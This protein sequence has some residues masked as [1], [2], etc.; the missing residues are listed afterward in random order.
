MKRIKHTIIAVLCAIALMG[1]EQSKPCIDADDFGFPKIRLAGQG[2]EVEGKEG[3][4][5][6]KWSDPGLVIDGSQVI[7]DVYGRWFPWLEGDLGIV[8]DPCTYKTGIQYPYND[9]PGDNSGI[10]INKLDQPCWLTKGMGVYGLTVATDASGTNSLSRN[11]T[12]DPI[13]DPN[14][15]MSTRMSPSNANS[16][17]MGS[18]NSSDLTPTRIFDIESDPGGGPF[19]QGIHLGTYDTMGKAGKTHIGDRLYFKLLDTF[20]GDNGGSVIV[21]IRSGARSPYPGV[22]ERII[23]AVSDIFFGSAE[24]IFRQMASQLVGVV[25]ALLILYIAIYGLYYMMGMIS[26]N[27]TQAVFLT[28]VLKFGVVAALLSPTSFEFFHNYLLV[29]FVDGAKSAI[30]IVSNTGFAGSERLTFFDDV[31]KKLFSEE[32]NIKIASLLWYPNPTDSWVASLNVKGL[33]YIPV[34]YI[35]IAFFAIALLKALLVY[36]MTVVSLGLLIAVAPILI[37]FMLFSRTKELYEG[38]L[39]SLISL[40]IQPVILFAFL[41]LMYVILMGTL[42]KTLGYRTCWN[43]WWSGSLIGEGGVIDIVDASSSKNSL[44]AWMPNIRNK[45]DNILIPP[46][47]YSTYNTAGCTGDT[48]TTNVGPDGSS[49]TFL[50]VQCLMI[51]THCRLIDYPS[52]NPPDG[53]KC[54]PSSGKNPIEPYD[55]DALDHALNGTVTSF[56]DVFFFGVVVFLMLLFSDK[57]P[58]LARSLTGMAHGAA[59]ETAAGGLWSN[60]KSVASN[61]LGVRSIG[62]AAFTRARKAAGIG[63]LTKG[64]THWQD[65]VGGAWDS[66]KDR[67]NKGVK[68]TALK[69]TGTYDTY[70]EL[71]K[72]NEQGAKSIQGVQDKI[73]GVVGAPGKLTGKLDPRNLAEKGV[74][75][76]AGGVGGLGGKL[77]GGLAYGQKK[78]EAKGLLTGGNPAKKKLEEE[79]K[80][81][82]EQVGRLD[83][84]KDKEKI[85]ALTKQRQEISGK[86]DAMSKTKT[87]TKKDMQEKSKKLKEQINGL[88]P[89]TD[90]A[91]IEELNKQRQH[92]ENQLNSLVPPTSMIQLNQ[93]TDKSP[94]VE[95]KEGPVD[96]EKAREERLQLEKAQRE[97]EQMEKTEQMMKDNKLKISE[98][99]MQI[100]KQQQENPE[101][102]N[103]LIQLQSDLRKVESQLET[104]QAFKDLQLQ[105]NELATQLKKHTQEHPED[106]EGLNRL[107]SN[108]NKIENQIKTNEPYAKEKEEIKFNIQDKEP[109]KTEDK[110]DKSEE[111]LRKAELSIDQKGRLEQEKSRLEQQEKKK[112]EE[113]LPGEDL[114]SKKDELATQLEKRKLE[115][116]QLKKQ[117]DGRLMEIQNKIKSLDKEKDKEVIERL[118]NEVFGLKNEIG[119]LDS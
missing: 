116:A 54:T 62:Q 59:L 43:T 14:R 76:V 35:F 72:F 47:Y 42:Y 45:W 50:D 31:F 73:A 69:A 23:N 109:L 112:G 78:P 93:E 103:T 21:K 22:F 46:F 33:L 27:T 106:K 95:R 114:A 51:G 79:S 40:A 90:K 12:F 101:G 17:H 102:Q 105:R 97:K 107:Q 89:V 18:P 96:I 71:A 65:K 111:E 118:Q 108:L 117:L 20:Y 63:S 88:N 55:T 74:K 49:D 82:K 57:V 36:L 110:K 7:F 80:K 60:V 4:Q 56:E 67:L 68:R 70:K 77:Y 64:F 115:N 98:L 39:K 1:C 75:K 66:G 85:E 86:L 41:T 13:S 24:I 83:P 87:T 6:S 53:S 30:S 26:P 52:L 11:W 91:K 81:L 34:L 29:L 32:T 58:E 99:N 94:V 84:K 2:L 8:R 113:R 100:R 16:F 3:N 92:I 104:T 19:K 15:N 5:V 28:R 37:P 38:W 9:R 48:G 44:K 10:A 25:R 61:P 119:K